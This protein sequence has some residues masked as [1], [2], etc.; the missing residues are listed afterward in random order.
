MISIEFTSDTINTLF[1]LSERHPQPRVRKKM[2][3]LYLKSQNLPHK[4]ILRLTRICENT[5]LKYLNEYIN[6]GL[7]AL[8]I[9][10]F[11]RPKSDLSDCIE[12][13]KKS[14]ND[15]PP[16]SSKEAAARIATLTGILRS[17]ER[18]RI[19][20]RKM[21]MAYRKTGSIPAKA[22]VEKQEKFLSEEL[23]PRILDAK[24]GKRA[25]FL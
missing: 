1:D 9:S 13:I 2:L 12:Q 20:M 8:K 11:Y 10:H 17:P 19:F 5:L 16:S 23:E 21:G 4:E 22:D 24:N 25:I 6:E 3:V 7:E 14:F 15:N 18:I